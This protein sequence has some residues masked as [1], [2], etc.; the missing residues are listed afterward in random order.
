MTKPAAFYAGY[1]S[2]VAEI[3][4][5]GWI[6]ARDKFNLEQPPGMKWSGSADGLAYAQGEFQ[7]LSDYI[8][9]KAIASEIEVAGV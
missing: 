1:E 3:H 4:Q 5:I 7:A 9:Y 6:S 8:G 2:K